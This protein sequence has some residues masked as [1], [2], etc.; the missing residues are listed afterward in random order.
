VGRF[1]RNPPEYYRMRIERIEKELSAKPFK[2]DLYD[3]IAVAHERLHESDKAIAWME[4]KRK[5]LAGTSPKD[6]NF[7]EHW[8]R[9][10]ANEGTFYAHRWV[11]KRDSKNLKDLETAERMI[12][13][14]LEIK[15]DAHFGR[16]MYQHAALKW[17]LDLQTHQTDLDL[18]GYLLQFKDQPAFTDKKRVA[19]GL[20]GLVRLGGAWQSPDVF[21]ALYQNL[22]RDR[23]A[24]HLAGMAGLRTN[25]LLT[26]GREPFGALAI[27]AYGKQEEP[28]FKRLRADAD[29][30]HDQRT[31]FMLAQLKLGKHPDTDANFW[32]GYIERPLPQLHVRNPLMRSFD[33]F[34][35]GGWIQLM[36]VVMLGGFLA[37]LAVAGIRAG[38]SKRVS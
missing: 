22:R 33:R 19:E 12:A 2:L 20:A 38:L 37:L 25:E 34:A 13:K 9:L 17:I 28:E 29:A 16:E 4:K 32:N 27:G 10:Y 23:Q 6:I 11:G 1:D 5:A 15:P 8:Y 7:K 3:D 31:Q 26:E 30:W 36:P 21:D 18:N 14:A 24:W 35:S